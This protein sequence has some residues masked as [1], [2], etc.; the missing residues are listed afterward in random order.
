MSFIK[1]KLEILKEKDVIG[2]KMAIVP[3]FPFQIKTT[4]TATHG[5]L[6]WSELQH[7]INFLENIYGFTRTV[8]IQKK[9]DEYLQTTTDFDSNALY[10]SIMTNNLVINNKESFGLE[11][12]FV[13]RPNQFPYDF[14][15]NEHYLVWIHPNC[16]SQLKE[17]IFTKNGLND[18]IDD[19]IL[20]HNDSLNHLER[21]E[22]LL[23]RNAS[24][25]KS[26]L[27]IEHFH[28]IFKME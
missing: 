10:E 21:K 20:L 3:T 16:S 19:L 8:P 22:R 24:I 13:F 2:L 18:I 15:K 7:S 12:Q 28:V 5:W 23:F 1:Y 26:V 11:N 27:S 17:K 9:Y 14:G 25:N 4:T 6:S